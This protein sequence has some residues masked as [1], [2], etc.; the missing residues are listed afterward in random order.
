M[1][2]CAE[3]IVDVIV[4]CGAVSVLVKH[5]QAP[6]A[7]DC[8]DAPRPYEHEVEKGSAF[9]LG[10]L[11]VKVIQYVPSRCTLVIYYYFFKISYHLVSRIHCLIL[12]SDRLS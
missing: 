6:P 2:F 3:E 5:L 4:D 8:D 9:S 10:L 7:R 1:R 11:A 12:F